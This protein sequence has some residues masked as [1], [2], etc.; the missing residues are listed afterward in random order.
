MQADVRRVHVADEVGRYIVD[1]VRAT[2]GNEQVRVGASPR[3]ALGL[4]RIAQA[5]A[6]MDGRDHVRPD[7]VQNAAV[8]VLA[9]R[10]VLETKAQYSGVHKANVIREVLD[11]VKVPR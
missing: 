10:L 11:R 2:R 8:P 9:H 5:M 3:G 6:M 7:D 1:L 4:F